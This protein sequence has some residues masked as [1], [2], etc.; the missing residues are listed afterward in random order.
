MPITFEDAPLNQYAVKGQDFR[1]RCR[2]RA[3]PEPQ[4]DWKK[5]HRVINDSGKKITRKS[6]KNEK[7]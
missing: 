3:D 2:V 5:D 4:V 6:K 1:V 7:T